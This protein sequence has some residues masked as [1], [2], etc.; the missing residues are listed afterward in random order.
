MLKITEV[1]ELPEFVKDE[2]LPIVSDGVTRR[3]TLGALAGGVTPLLQNRYKGDQGEAGLRGYAALTL[4]QLKA[5]PVAHGSLSYDWAV[6]GFDDSA[7][8]SALWDDTRYVRSDHHPTGAWVRQGADKVHDAARESVLVAPTGASMVGV[9]P[10][11]SV[12]Y[13]QVLSDVLVGS[14]VSVYR[15]VP[16]EQISTMRDFTSTYDVSADIKRA[17]EDGVQR[18]VAEYGL[19]NAEQSI[20]LDKP[21]ILEGAGQG[22]IFD[23][24]SVTGKATFE[25]KSASVAKFIDGI[26]LRNFTIRNTLGTFAEQ[27]HLIECSGV[28]NALFEGLHLKGF[29]GDGIYI[30][31]GIGSNYRHNKNVH[32]V[33]NVF[34]GVNRLNR[35]GVSVIDADGIFIDRN[36]FTR[37]SAANMPG[38]IDFEPNANAWHIVRNARVRDN[39]FIDNGGNVAEIGFY[40][41]EVVEF[42]MQDIEVSGNHSRGYAGSGNFLLYNASRAF[43]ATGEDSD[44]RVYSNRAN[45]GTGRPFSV[46]NGKKVSFRDNRWSDYAQAALIGFTGNQ[47]RDMTIEGDRFTRVGSVG[48]HGVSIFNAVDLEMRGVKFNDC[49]TGVG[50]AANA[51]QFNT[52]TSSGVRIDDLEVTS[53]TG[54]TLIAIQK[55][56]GHTF[57]PTTNRLRRAQIGTLANNF[58]A[59]DN[60][61]ALSAYP[62]ATPPIIEGGSSVGAGTYTEA[63]ARYRCQGDWVTGYARFNVASHTGSGPIEV[64]LPR[65]AA[66]VNGS[67][68]AR[69]IGVWSITGIAGINGPVEARLNSPASAGGN[70]GAIR[71]YTV[72]NGV[73]ALVNI[74][75]DTAFIVEGVFEYMAAARP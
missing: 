53:P 73:E 51:I 58:Q 13:L 41:P 32:I 39:I 40:S 49:G 18:M 6:F 10:P 48:G 24:R 17:A 16:R 69:T 55:E 67:T 74:P 2:T 14:P 66:N 12:P 70:A 59:E 25:F 64:S 72:T 54:K 33:R 68:G 28:S 36:L 38:A 44:L 9:E 4:A 34:D 61:K 31:A 63:F 20:L 3:T 65:P 71:F 42:P 11:H 1:P 52:G 56:A 35:N 30:G 37:C 57:N 46:I 8:Y 15:L 45:G 50:G 7:D 27:Q 5:A 23:Q 62:A 60:D 47:V 19:Y 26:V 43:T 75:A 29:R 21:L 22:T